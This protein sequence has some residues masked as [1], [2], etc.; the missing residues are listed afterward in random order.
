MKLIPVLFKKEDVISDF[1]SD[2]Q[3]SNWIYNKLKS[4]KIVKIRN[5]LYALIDVS[6]DDVYVN[7]FE[8]ASK[9]SQTGCISYQSALEYYGLIKC[10]KKEVIVSSCTKF[11]NFKFE[12][13]KYIYH[14]SISND[15]IDVINRV[16]VTSIERTIV[17]CI[18]NI[19]IAV[20]IDT[21]LEAIGNLKSLDE[22]KLIQILDIY[23]KKIMYQKAG[24]IF[25][26][27]RNKLLISD[28]FFDYCKQKIST[29][30]TYFLDDDYDDLIYNK[31]WNLYCPKELI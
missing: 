19:S 14:A 15:F 20:G 11:N 13:V 2:K 25:E 30:I 16:R 27:F 4:H 6:V 31:K 21:L 3:Y 5:D 23:D 26:L 1:K 22:Y 8:M 7:K 10:E 28:Y 12:D 18:N 17:D 29:K 9:I 24:Y